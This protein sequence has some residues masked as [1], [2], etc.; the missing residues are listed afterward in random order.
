MNTYLFNTTTKMKPYNCGKYWIDSNIVQNKR[1]TANS[2]LDALKEFCNIVEHDYY[3]EISKN[4]INQKR[5]MFIDN[6]DGIAK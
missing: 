5:E 6:K 1:I 4:A 2:V 3:I